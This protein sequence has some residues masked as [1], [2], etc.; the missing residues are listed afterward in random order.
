MSDAALRSIKL[1]DKQFTLSDGGGLFLLAT[2]NGS[3]LWRLAYR[4]RCRQNRFSRMFSMAVG[5][6]VRKYCAETRERDGGRCG[7]GRRI[8]RSS[9]HRPGERL[10]RRKNVSPAGETRSLSCRKVVLPRRY[11]FAPPVFS[12]ARCSQTSLQA[13]RRK[14]C[15]LSG[16]TGS[17]RCVRTECL[18]PTH[19]T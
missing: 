2:P 15:S 11:F 14:R 19:R 9:R 4:F 6:V 10:R 8:R 13:R 17:R 7:L 3:R 5:A 16:H 18:K 12:P 1:R